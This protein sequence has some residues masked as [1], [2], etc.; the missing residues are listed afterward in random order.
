MLHRPLAM[1]PHLRSMAPLLGRSIH[2]SAR[3]RSGAWDHLWIEVLGMGHSDI[4]LLMAALV[5]T[6][7]RSH[8]AMPSLIGQSPLQQVLFCLRQQWL[9][10][11]QPLLLALPPLMLLLAGPATILEPHITWQLLEAQLGLLQELMVRAQ[12]QGTLTE[13]HPRLTLLQPRQEAMQMLSLAGHHPVTHPLIPHE[14]THHQGMQM[15]ILRGCHTHQPHQQRLKWSTWGYRLQMI[16]L[17]MWQTAEKVVG[18]GSLH[19]RHQITPLFL[20]AEMQHRRNMLH[21]RTTARTSS[22]QLT[23]LM[24]L[25]STT[26]V[27]R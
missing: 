18:M 11:L 3:L 21:L 19:L 15:C 9:L 26:L 12:E 14:L 20:S 10:G 8:L 5:L 2:A 23:E 7:R 6:M 17:D 27:R 13:D 16:S 25:S 4:R 24:G 22:K 1:A